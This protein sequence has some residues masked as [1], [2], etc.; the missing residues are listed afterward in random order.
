[1]TSLKRKASQELT[2][3]SI[4]VI[5]P[6]HGD[7]MFET[8][9]GWFWGALEWFRRRVDPLYTDMSYSNIDV[10][11]D[12]HIQ[13]AEARED[14][15]TAVK[16]QRNKSRSDEHRR[17]SS[18]QRRTTSIN[19]DQS[20][21]LSE[22]ELRAQTDAQWIPPAFGAPTKPVEREVIV[23]SDDDEGENEEER[24]KSIADTLRSPRS[25]KAPTIR[26][27]P[28]SALRRSSTATVTDERS[29]NDRL[30]TL[31]TFGDEQ[32]DKYGP[33]PLAIST[34]AQEKHKKE[35][36]AQE[37]KEKQEKIR[38]AKER[39]LTRRDPSN[40]L[41]HALDDKWEDI[42]CE[43]LDR[44]RKNG[45]L[46]ITQSQGGTPLHYK[47]FGTLL[48][49]NSWLN[50]EIINTY[51]EWV[52][53]AANEFAKEEAK[54]FG[55]PA[56]KVPKFIAHNSFFYENLDKKGP[57]STQRLMGRKKAPGVSLL[58]VDTVFVPI[59]RGSH[60]T[61][62]VVRPMARTIEYFDSLQGSPKTFIKLMRG[63]LKFQLGADYK[64]DEWKTPNTGCT[65]QM[66]GYDCGV[67]VCTNALCVALGVNTDCYNGTD[68]TTMR[69]NIAAL[70]I[71]K[72]F[73]GDFAWGRGVF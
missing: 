67:F 61:V 27:P 39:R 66:N 14:G 10:V 19:M 26:L 31:L 62:G 54:I 48:G 37:L 52:V 7:E 63:W 28:M 8:I 34:R 47:D 25:P 30:A 32:D 21:S 55:E 44:A 49:R 56:G 45:N 33:S 35:R 69:R 29:L 5:E 42:V 50:D 59:C 72:G 36:E 2:H 58:Q 3:N 16:R 18:H 71:N 1:M 43:A 53:E 70:L 22:E 17:T 15:S 23:I 38:I 60:W 73:Q 4:E 51:I 9:L 68:M 57:S 41:V 64:E 40:R 13:R 65:R 6:I 20:K 24:P 12:E 11:A 46:P